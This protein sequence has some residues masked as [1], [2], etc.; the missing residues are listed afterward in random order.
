MH[1]SISNLCSDDSILD[2]L[3]LLRDDLGLLSSNLGCNLSL[4][5]LATHMSML[6]Q[7]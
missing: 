5:G 3:F 6:A 4:V 7:A 1:V 2:L